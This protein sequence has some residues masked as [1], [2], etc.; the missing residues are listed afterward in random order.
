MEGE[1]VEVVRVDVGSPGRL[2]VGGEEHAPQGQ[3]VVQ[4]EDRIDAAG[5]AE[6]DH[7]QRGVGRLKGVGQPGN[8][9]LCRHRRQVDQ[10]DADIEVGQHPRLGE[11]GREGVLTH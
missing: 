10:L 6:V 1:G 4:L 11:L 5:V 7:Q 8:R 2:P 3:L 9:V